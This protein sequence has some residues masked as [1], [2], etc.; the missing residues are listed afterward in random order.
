MGASTPEQVEHLIKLGFPEVAGYSQ[1]EFEMRAGRPENS[2]GILVVSELLVTI[3]QQCKILGINNKL[4]LEQLITHENTVPLPKKFLYWCYEIDDGGAVKGFAPEQAIQQLSDS[5]RFPAHTALVLAIFRRN[6]A[7]IGKDKE[8]KDKR[9]DIGGSRIEGS[10]IPAFLMGN[11]STRE[12][13]PMLSSTRLDEA[14][15]ETYGMPS[16]EKAV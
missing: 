1:H 7:V 15:K 6:P 10:L 14:G 3:P 5:R 4:T 13:Q 2:A 16:F 9:I 8:G 12:H 11:G